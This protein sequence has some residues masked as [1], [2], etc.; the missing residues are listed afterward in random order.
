MY[1]NKLSPLVL[2]GPNDVVVDIWFGGSEIMGLGAR[3]SELISPTLAEA[4]TPLVNSSIWDRWIDDTYRL[5]GNDEP[6]SFDWDLIPVDSGSSA[7]RTTFAYGQG[8]CYT[9]EKPLAAPLRNRETDA[10]HYTILV[11][12]SNSAVN[13]NTATI[14]Q[15]LAHWSPL[16]TGVGELVDGSTDMGALEHLKTNYIAPAMRNLQTSNRRIFL[17]GIYMSVSGD[18]LSG[19]A[20]ADVNEWTMHMNMIR[21]DLETFLGF[22]GCPWVILGVTQASQNVTTGAD[23]QDTLRDL[24]EAYCDANSATTIYFSTVG[25]PTDDKFHFD[26][27]ATLDIGRDA[28]LV[29]YSR[30][31][32]GLAEITKVF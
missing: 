5:A 24:Q 7:D 29:R 12:V 9:N 13:D 8:L 16:V 30:R 15:P 17:G 10:Y 2:P 11:G 31:D 4:P 18:S 27:Q 14:A 3:T 19:Y 32:L 20:P 26:G 23:M 28:T 6:D 22:Q 25:Y 21:R 1:R